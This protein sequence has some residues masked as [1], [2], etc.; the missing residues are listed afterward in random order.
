MYIHGF[1]DGILAA[2]VLGMAALITAVVIY[3]RKKK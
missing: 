2:V 1:I 3:S